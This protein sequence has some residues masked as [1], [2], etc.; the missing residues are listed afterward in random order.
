MRV[1]TLS[2]LFLCFFTMCFGQS[3]NP[4]EE[5]LMT[6]ENKRLEAVAS[7]NSEFLSN[8]YDNDF[9]GIV[10]SGHTVDKVKMMEFLGSYNPYVIQSIEDVRIRVYTDVAVSTGKLLSKSKSGS[11]IGQTRF[12]HVYVKRNDQWK[13]IESQGTLVIVE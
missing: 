4:A 6:I 5:A 3:G 9:H 8:L 11:V 12:T 2:C 13:I 7:R 10:A 1:I